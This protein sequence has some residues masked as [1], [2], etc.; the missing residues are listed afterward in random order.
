MRFHA[1]LAATALLAA[2]AMAQEG[3]PVPAPPAKEAEA[4]K[5][6]NKVSAAAKAALEKIASIVYTPLK[7]GLQDLTGAVKM[8]AE[9]GP[10]GE[11]GRG[12]M[13]GAGRIDL[14]FAVA[15]KA[16]SDLKVEWKDLPGK[17]EADKAGGMGARMMQGMSER[18]GLAVSRILRGTLEGFVPA[19]DAEYDAELVVKEGVSVLILTT[20]LK[21][22]EVSHQELTL[23][24]NGLPSSI[25]TTSAG[26]GARAADGK[27]TGKFT[28][29]KE[30]DL[31]RL[32]KMT[33]DGPRGPMEAKLEYADAGKFKVVRSW[34]LAPAGGPMKFVF[35][36]SELVVNGKAVD[37]PA[38]PK[39]EEKEK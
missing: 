29:A 34:E 19:S 11:G 26:A 9:M 10:A 35:R 8:E 36:F 22:V 27:T 20:Y 14:T 31:F 6:V 3:G 30:G 25:V 7:G 24:A 12:R 23:D 13:G 38:S 2:P 21:G 5:H 16:P 17:E 37:L 39:P 33:M 32:E 18:M 4:P 28:Y 1:L 15:F